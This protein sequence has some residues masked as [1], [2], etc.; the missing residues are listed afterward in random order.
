MEPHRRL[1]GFRTL[2]PFEVELCESIGISDKEYFEFLDLV[3]AKPVEA[4]IVAGPAAGAWALYSGTFAAGNFA[5][6]F[7]GQVVVSLALAAAS[8]LLTPK[9][10]DPGQSPRLTIGGVQGR[11]RFNRTSGF[12]SL[13]D[14]ASLGSFIPLVYARQGVRVSS[15][16]LWSQVRTTQYGETINAIVLFSN[17]EIGSK[18]EYESLALGET[19]LSDLPLSKQ[20]IY[21]SRGARLE[22]RLQ[23]LSDGQTP[24]ISDDQYAEGISKNSNNYGFRF[25]REYDDSDPFMVKIYE[26]NRFIYKPSF[27]STKTLSTNNKFGLY[28]P[29]PN[30]NAYKVPWELLLLAKD[31]DDDIKR[32]SRVKMGKITHLYPRYVG[33]TNRVESLSLIHI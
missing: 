19:F 12:D 32:D 27:S 24:T 29:M 18:P 11:S 9:P 22:G 5:L 15:Q 1:G 7:L 33:I 4:D 25:N 26:S 28:S 14:L 3:D 21:F 23:G 13:Q 10:K 17:G 8:Y 30:G 31:G 20:K 16:L 2:L 6:T